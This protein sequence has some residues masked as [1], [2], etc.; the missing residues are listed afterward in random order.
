L[1]DAFTTPTFTDYFVEIR[2]QTR[3]GF[4]DDMH[5][6][7]DWKPIEKILRKKYRKVARAGTINSDSDISGFAALY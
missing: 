6:L 4:L 7:I 1:K 3:K 2:R 5:H